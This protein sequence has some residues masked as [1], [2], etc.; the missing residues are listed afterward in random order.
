MCRG[1]RNSDDAGTQSRFDVYAALNQFDESLTS[2]GAQHASEQT[3]A[4]GVAS[5]SDSVQGGRMHAPAELRR[6]RLQRS[7]AA[8]PLRTPLRSGLPRS[9][10]GGHQ[11]N[12]GVAHL[13]T[14][15][16]VPPLFLQGFLTAVARCC[17]GQPRRCVARCRQGE[18]VG[19]PSRGGAWHAEILTLPK[20]LMSTLCEL[21]LAEVRSYAAAGIG[22]TAV[23]PDSPV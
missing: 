16:Y 12:S 8:G 1:Y 9:S 14:R 13:R 23:S 10:G 11:S 17:R 5:T 4:R 20:L 19:A 6:T 7:S 21:V 2:R 15:R 22:H 3:S 18:A